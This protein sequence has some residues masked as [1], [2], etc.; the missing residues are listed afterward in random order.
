[1]VNSDEALVFREY[2]WKRADSLTSNYKFM[3]HIPMPDIDVCRY[4]GSTSEPLYLEGWES[5]LAIGPLIKATPHKNKWQ[6]VGNNAIISGEILQFSP[7][8]I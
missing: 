3:K 4:Q 6:Q 1:M 8:C 2:P 5:L 7:I